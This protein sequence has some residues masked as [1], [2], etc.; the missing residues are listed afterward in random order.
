MR[1]KGAGI[2]S[3]YNPRMK[4]LTFLLLLSL[5]ACAAPTQVPTATPSPVP[6][7][8][9]ATAT[10]SPIPTQDYEATVVARVKL[11]ASLP[12]FTP[13]PPP[14][15]LTATPSPTVIPTTRPT[16]TSAPLPTPIPTLTPTSTPERPTPTPTPVADQALVTAEL[17][18]EK[19]V[20]WVE[21]GTWSA[22]GGWEGKPVDMVQFM[23]GLKPGV[24][25]STHSEYLPVSMVDVG[26]ID[27]ESRVAQ[28][29]FAPAP[30][31]GHT[32]KIETPDN[33]IVASA[34]ELVGTEYRFFV[35]LVDMRDTI[36][37]G[38]LVFNIHGL[39]PTP[40]RQNAT[41]FIALRRVPLCQTVSQ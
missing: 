32:G 24:T 5:F 35:I 14:P 20:Y 6:T 33:V 38:D 13:E 26:A 9:P 12:T 27:D 37:R 4:L 25:L 10:P 29:W 28:F 3:L 7:E 16:A 30:P 39:P 11:S 36:D 31:E 22:C 18:E 19:W 1:L 34:W 21:E 2:I 15:T 17:F 8:A 40:E 23:F 41:Q